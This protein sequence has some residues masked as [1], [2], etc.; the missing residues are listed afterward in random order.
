MSLSAT[1]PAANHQGLKVAIAAAVAMAVTPIV[2]TVCLGGTT[3][4]SAARDGVSCGADASVM[5]FWVA[6]RLDLTAD[7]WGERQAF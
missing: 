2:V 4:A 5:A 6:H 7:L 1:A 3:A